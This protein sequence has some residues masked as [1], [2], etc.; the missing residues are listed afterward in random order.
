M[1]I[2]RTTTANTGFMLL[3]GL[4]IFGRLVSY[5]FSFNSRFPF[6]V[7]GIFVIASL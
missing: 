4:G 3:L 7:F 6:K 5:F 2:N 1:F